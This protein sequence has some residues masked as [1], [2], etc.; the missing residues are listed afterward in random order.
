MT[1]SDLK[2]LIAGGETLSVEFKD[3]TRKRLADEE[4]VEAVVCLA[5]RP[6][7]EAGW[8]FVGVDD[9][10]GVTGAQP[11]HGSDINPRRVQALIA[12]RTVPSLSCRVEVARLDGKNV[13]VIEVPRARVPVGTS[14]GVYTRRVIGQRGEP[15]CL[16]LHFYEMQAMGVHG[17]R[18]D[19]SA[20]V[21]EGVSLDDLDPLE[22]DRY[23]RFIRESG[24]DR[25]LLGLS[26]PDLARALGAVETRNGE[27]AVR[28]LALLLFGKPDVIADLLPAHEVA[29]QALSHGDVE[30][31]D[32]FRWPLLRVVEELETRFR[33]HNREQEIQ[34]GLLRIAVPDY[35]PRAFRE[36]IANALIHRDYSRLGPV[37]VQW[38]EDELQITS[39]GAF[40]EGVRLD[41]LLVIEPRPRNPLLADALKRA[42]VVERTGRGIDA[43]FREQVRNGRPAPDYRGSTDSSVRLTLPGG[44]AN[45]EFVRLVSEEAQKDRALPLDQLLILNH[46]RM[47]REM[48][49]GEAARL[50]QKPDRH[51]RHALER[52]KESGLIE[53]DGRRRRPRFR[54]SGRFPQPRGPI[55]R[56]SG[57]ERTRQEQMVIRY[58]EESGR[59]T[60]SVAAELC[61]IDPRMA[62]QL[63]GKMVRDGQIEMRGVR[64]GAWYGLPGQ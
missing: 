8:L 30:V 42:G 15:E 44:K 12:N 7:S 47:D 4:L 57:V 46:L 55:R 6:A 1:V 41:N 25:A 27:T 59:I 3:E 64:R 13:L 24:G 49:A 37:H 58:L 21:L 39:P 16:P 54:L 29:F 53:G 2:D 61:G 18:L 38:L 50:I 11:R 5:N 51:A 20:L 45:L 28:A 60:R 33:A 32:F 36:G 10:G 40:P 34:V 56:A 63:L 48:D 31:N 26:D 17:G 52:L 9:R 62:T 35:A 43:I 23:R 22:F 14:R 19:Y